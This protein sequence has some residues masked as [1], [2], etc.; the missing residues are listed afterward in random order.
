MPY[1]RLYVYR[2]LI[3]RQSEGGKCARLAQSLD[4]VDDVGAAVV[5][6]PDLA[7]KHMVEWSS[8]QRSRNERHRHWLHPSYTLDTCVVGNIGLQGTNF[9]RRQN[10]HS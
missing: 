2:P 4:L 10:I 7:C 6:G 5:A 3:L 1:S 9:K 8:L